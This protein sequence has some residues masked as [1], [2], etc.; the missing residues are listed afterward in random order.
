MDDPDADGS[1]M[2]KPTMFPPT[3]EE[4]ATMHLERCIRCLP[5]DQDTGGFFICL[6]E[7]VC[8]IGDDVAAYEEAL[9]CRY[10]LHSTL[11]GG[12]ALSVLLSDLRE[13]VSEQLALQ[14]EQQRAIDLGEIYSGKQPTTRIQVRNQNP[15]AAASGADS[16]PVP[17][18]PESFLYRW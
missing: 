13:E 18:F 6:F 15:R 14:S 11:D 9:A 16:G 2:L 5:Q 8:P 4:A 7:K 10:D 17:L 12:R 3:A 1:K